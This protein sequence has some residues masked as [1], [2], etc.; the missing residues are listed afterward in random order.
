V[1]AADQRLL[2][3]DFVALLCVQLA[4]G[5][6]FATFFLLPKFMVEELF[7][8]PTQVGLVSAGFGLASVCSMPGV[9]RMC[10]Y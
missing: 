7:A 8:S 9:G 3:P 4:T 2:K 1:R 10:S 5:F 6:A